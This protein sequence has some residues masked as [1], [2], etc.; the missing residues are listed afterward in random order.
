MV[1]AKTVLL[2]GMRADVLE[3]AKQELRTPGIEFLGGTSV[4][5][6]ESAFRRVDID[7]MIIGG[8][9]ILRSGLPRSGRCSSPAMGNRAHERPGA[10][11]GEVP[12]VCQGRA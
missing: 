5:A 3:A 2:L 4:A 12:P 10:R 1:M 6:A 8:V 9:W 7:H 11:G